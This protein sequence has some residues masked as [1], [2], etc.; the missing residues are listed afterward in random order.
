MIVKDQLL[1]GK[2]AI[3]TGGTSGIG[4]SVAQRFSKE[5]AK[6]IIVGR[7]AARGEQALK[8]LSE[9]G[10]SAIFLQADVCSPADCDS[11]VEETLRL[12]SRLDILFNNAGLIY[13]DRTVLTTSEAEWDATMNVN[14]KGTFLM[15][16]AVIPSMILGGGGS[17][18]NDASVFG[19]VA[20]SGVAAYCAAKGAI[21]MLTKAMAIDHAQQRIRVNCV[22]PGSVDT[23]LLKEEMEALGGVELQKPKFA[24]R[25]PLNRVAEPDEIANAVLFLASNESSFI[26]GVAMP[27]DGGR[28]AW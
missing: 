25:H 6:V 20:G 12:H 21:I 10:A 7:S 8:T 4:L 15:S 23:P 22:C 17:I 16:K 27:V 19:L 9:S 11:V 1:A 18:I 26:T 14:V 13:V 3:I 5:G 28:S 2:V 24:A